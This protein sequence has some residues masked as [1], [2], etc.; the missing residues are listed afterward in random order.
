SSPQVAAA[1][2]AAMIDGEGWITVRQWSTPKQARGCMRVIGIANTERELIDAC[3]DACEQLGIRPRL[4][5]IKRQRPSWSRKWEIQIIRRDSLRIVRDVVPIQSKRKSAKLDE[6]LASYWWGTAEW[7][8]RK[9]NANRAVWEKR[10]AD[11]ER[12]QQ[13]LRNRSIAAKLGRE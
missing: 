2:L 6:A 8:E 10:R 3:I 11:P 13:W 5:E 7:R 9:S 1:Y 12:M 4:Y